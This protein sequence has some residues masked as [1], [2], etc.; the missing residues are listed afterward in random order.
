MSFLSELL[1]IPFIHAPE[2]SLHTKRR[3]TLWEPDPY[4]YAYFSNSIGGTSTCSVVCHCF[5]S[6][7][8]P[9]PRN[10]SDGRIAV[11]ATVEATSYGVGLRSGR[12][13][14]E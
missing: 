5:C 8:L 10:G 9:L 6:M 2:K 13:W 11:S 1:S 3:G 7:L 14:G 12:G 4:C